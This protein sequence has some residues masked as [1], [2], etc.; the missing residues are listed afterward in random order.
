MTK[1]T[2]EQ[3]NARAWAI[4]EGLFYSDGEC[5]VPWQPF[6]DWDD[7]ELQSEV[8]GLA[9]AIFSSMVWAQGEDE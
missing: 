4:A 2:K 9:A 8:A 5:D 1:P 6:E 3:M 7:A